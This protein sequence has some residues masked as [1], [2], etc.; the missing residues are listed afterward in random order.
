M[1][2]LIF[3]FNIF[4]GLSF[5]VM[6]S[7]GVFNVL[8]VVGLVPRFAGKT[9][10]ARYERIYENCIII[11]TV[12]GCVVSVFDI[13]PLRL[14]KIFS[15]GLLIFIGIFAGIFVGCLAIAAAELLDAIPIFAR[16]AKMKK[17][18]G[19]AMIAIAFG[20][21]AGSL[22]YFWKHFF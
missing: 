3:I 10:T 13:S 19:I 6:V 1:N 2:W 8:F 12:F 4:M 5:G 14:D 11:G 7:A 9:H 20:K 21:V 15:A 18:L 17:G 22:L 16:R